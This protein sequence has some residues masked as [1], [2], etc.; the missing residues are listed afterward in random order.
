MRKAI[1]IEK[2]ITPRKPAMMMVT[3]SQGLE[4]LSSPM[5]PGSVMAKNMVHRCLKKSW[6]RSTPGKISSTS[7]RISTAAPRQIRN[8]TTRLM[9]IEAPPLDMKFSNL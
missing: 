4:S 7:Q 6:K 2:M 1:N 9:K 3:L 8:S 5:L